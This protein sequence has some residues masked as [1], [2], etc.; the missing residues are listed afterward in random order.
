MGF[1]SNG[2]F[3]IWLPG[4]WKGWL[5]RGWGRVGEGLEEGCTSKTPFEKLH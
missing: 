3:V 2:V 4:G 5:E 1:F